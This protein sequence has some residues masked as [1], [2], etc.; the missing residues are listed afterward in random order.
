[1]SSVRRIFGNGKAA[2]KPAAEI[3][4]DDM[5]LD[6]GPH[7][8]RVRKEAS[9]MRAHRWNGPAAVYEFDQFGREPRRSLKRL[10]DGC[11]FARRG[12]ETLAAIGEIRSRRRDFYISTGG[13]AFLRVPRR[14]ELPRSNAGRR[15]QA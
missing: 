13:G 7:R 10:P 1:M 3:G 15:G 2:I 9:P 12:G 6:I 5:I 11:V 14:Q 8:G 4:S